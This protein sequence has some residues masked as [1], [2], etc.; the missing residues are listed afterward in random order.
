MRQA[1]SG[2]HVLGTLPFSSPVPHFP[3]HPLDL[4]H[5][6]FNFWHTLHI[7][8]GSPMHSFFIL[9][10]LLHGGLCL[11]SL[12]L[13]TLSCSS[14]RGHCAFGQCCPIHCQ[15][16]YLP[17]YGYHDLHAVCGPVHRWERSWHCPHCTELN[18]LHGH[19]FCHQFHHRHQFLLLL[20]CLTH[21]ARI[22]IKKA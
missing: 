2:D 11:T 21:W 9:V 7:W 5:L 15:S 8:F 3:P 12:S 4:L 19:W 14:P 10:D 1:Q 22:I 17:S 16:T 13:S 20:F 18:L 6:P